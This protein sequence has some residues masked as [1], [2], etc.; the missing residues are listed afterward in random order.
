MPWSEIRGQ[1]P[2]I[3]QLRPAIERGRVGHAYLFYGPKGVGKRTTARVFAQALTCRE[4][5]E[6][7]GCGKCRTCRNI[8]GGSYPDLHLVSSEGSLRMEHTQQIIR[9]AF[10]SPLEGERRIFIVLEVE[11]LT[12]EAG[13]NLLKVLEE[14]PGDSVFILTTTSLPGVLPTIRSRCLPVGFSPLSDQLVLELVREKGWAESGPESLV[15]NMAGGS[16]GAASAVMQS[17]GLLSVREE[18]MSL[19]ELLAQAVK[20]PGGKVKSE[21]TRVQLEVRLRV[22]ASLF[23]DLLVWQKTGT[24]ELLINRDQIEFIKRQAGHWNSPMRCLEIIENTNRRLAQNAN[25]PLL[26]EVCWLELAEHRGGF[27]ADS[28]RSTV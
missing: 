18:S 8:E 12:P 28:R 21:L 27:Y 4:E 25:L 10:I 24:E 15:V 23:R 2:A 3:S 1:E 20:S 14:P 13:N 16:P 22:M 11:K 7:G 17:G 6:N 19:I 9:Q 26:W 5:P